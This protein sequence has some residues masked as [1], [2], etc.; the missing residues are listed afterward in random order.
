M[1]QFT[2]L[3]D[4]QDKNVHQLDVKNICL[5]ATIMLVERP[6]PLYS[7]TLLGVKTFL[8][9]RIANNISA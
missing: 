8:E 3:P 2:I 9:N 5:Y 7:P 1:P 4:I 6:R